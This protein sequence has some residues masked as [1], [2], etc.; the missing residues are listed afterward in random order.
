M[1]FRAARRD[2]VLVDDPSEFV[3]AVK[4]ESSTSGRRAFTLPE[5]EAILGIADPEWRSLILFGLYSGQRLGDLARLTWAN[6]DLERNELRLVTEKTGRVVILPL[7]AP[8]RDHLESLPSADDVTSPIHPRA[9][10]TN[11]TTLSG[12]FVQLLVQAGLR[13]QRDNTSAAGGSSRHRQ[14]D[15]V[16]HSLRHTTVSLLHAGGVAQDVSE[17][18]VG[19][20]SNATHKLYVHS[21]RESLQ[22]A[23]D[24]LPTLRP[25]P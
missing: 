14:H 22:R 12:Q 10:A 25:R 4:A 6:V 2:G 9:A 13:A 15:L 16:F 18:F 8:L 19:H 11:K 17:T 7:A 1:L 5:L 24:L 23:A 3:N 20:S 21:D